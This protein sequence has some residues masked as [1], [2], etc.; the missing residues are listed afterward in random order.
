M[1]DDSDVAELRAQVDAMQ[2]QIDAQS[3][4]N[5]ELSEQLAQMQQDSAQAAP[6]APILA[7]PEDV[8]SQIHKQVRENINLHGQKHALS[9]SDLVVS[10]EAS[11]YIFQVSD[12][13]DAIDGDGEE[14][15]L[16]AGDLLKLDQGAAADASAVSMR[17]VTSKAGSCIA[18]TL[19]NVSVHDAQG[20]LNDFSKRQ[21]AI[22]KKLQTQRA[23]ANPGA[24]Q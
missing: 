10:G 1:T 3:Q 6:P 24:G 7:V 16:S 17:V 14:C 18:G 9:W 12:M 8:R 13:L 11:E 2:K 23:T 21:E 15:V 4:Q 20:M 5:E 22:M 19:V